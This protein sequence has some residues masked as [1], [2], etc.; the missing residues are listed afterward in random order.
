MSKA[1]TF[2]LN[3]LTKSI[4]SWLESILKSIMGGK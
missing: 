1:Q 2:A 4:D 3:S